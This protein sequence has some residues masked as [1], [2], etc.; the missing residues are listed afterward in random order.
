MDKLTSTTVQPWKGKILTP[1]RNNL[2]TEKS[3][4]MVCFY[5]HFYHWTLFYC[6]EEIT[7]YGI[8]TCSVARQR[9]YDMLR[10]FVMQQFQQG[11]CLKV[12][13]FMKNGVPPHIGR[14]V[15]QLLRKHFTNAK[16]YHPLLSNCMAA[17]IIP[18]D[19]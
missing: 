19:F 3:V 2:Y 4:N 16:V 15:K 18:H 1:S 11:S 14:R 17:D 12:I 6:F 13:I 5:G 10:H 7:A 8:Q 9:Y